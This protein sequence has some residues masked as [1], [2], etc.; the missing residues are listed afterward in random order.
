MVEIVSDDKKFDIIKVK[1]ISI[2]PIVEIS[3]LSIN[4]GEIDVLRKYVKT[5]T[6]TNKSRIEADFYCFTKKSNSIFKTFKNEYLLKPF[7]SMEV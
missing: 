5:L 1:A 3:K 4:F 2:G 6:I 7:Q